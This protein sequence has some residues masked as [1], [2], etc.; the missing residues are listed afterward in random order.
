M[1]SV[2]QKREILNHFLD[3]N[4]SLYSIMGICL[5]D[6]PED[7]MIQ[8]IHDTIVE[9]EDMCEKITQGK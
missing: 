2:E 6:S 1:L 8:T 4:K 7:I 5:K 3:C 9:L